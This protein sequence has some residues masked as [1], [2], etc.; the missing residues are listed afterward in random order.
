MFLGGSI[1]QQSNSINKNLDVSTSKFSER[2]IFFLKNFHALYFTDASFVQQYQTDA[3]ERYG[4]LSSNQI[5]QPRDCPED[6]ARRQA[7]QN[8]MGSKPP[9]PEIPP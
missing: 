4:A 7:L 5:N 6:S 3:A 9:C 2:I 1:R 8:R